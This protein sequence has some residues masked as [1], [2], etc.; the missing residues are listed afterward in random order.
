MNGKLFVPVCR[1]I[2][3]SV[4]RVDMW[5]VSMDDSPTSVLNKSRSPRTRLI[6]G[7]C[8]TS[9]GARSWGLQD[10]YTFGG[11]AEAQLFRPS[12]QAPVVWHT[13]IDA[14]VRAIGFTPTLSGLCVYTHGSGDTI[15]IPTLYDG[16]LITGKYDNVAKL[17][18]KALMDRLAVIDMREVSCLFGMTTTRDYHAGIPTVN[19]KT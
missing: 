2:S 11:E 19:Q 7:A 1:I 3:Q 9:S 13:T 14:E 18:N 10:R 15:V 17:L 4:R 5:H 16:I 6:R 8:Q 12:T